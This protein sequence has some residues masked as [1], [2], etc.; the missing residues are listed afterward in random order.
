MSYRQYRVTITPHQKKGPDEF[1]VKI[2]VKEFHDSGARLRHTYVPASF[3][4]EPNGREALRIKVKPIEVNLKAGY[5]VAIP[6]EIRIPGGG[7]LVIAQSAA[8]SEVV[9]P[10]GSKKDPPKATERTPVE[11]LYNVIEAT[12]LPNLADPIRQRC[13]G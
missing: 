5:R 8:G 12:T 3:D 10:P 11:M 1:Y 2:R 13:C 7:Y 6:K 9:V 4:S